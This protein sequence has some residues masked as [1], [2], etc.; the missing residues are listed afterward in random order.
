[1]LIFSL[2]YK[3]GPALPRKMIS[4]GIQQTLSVEVYPLVL[5]LIDSRDKS[6]VIIHISKKVFVSSFY[7][8]RCVVGEVSILFPCADP[9]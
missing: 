6:E 8:I 1:M 2:R 7:F 4:V 5:K 3:G 9:L